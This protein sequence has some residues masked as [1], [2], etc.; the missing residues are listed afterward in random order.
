[1]MTTRRDER[2]DGSKCSEDEERLRV[3]MRSLEAGRNVAGP[4]ECRYTY[5]H[6]SK[7]SWVLYQTLDKGSVMAPRRWV[8][9][10]TKGYHLEL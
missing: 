9:R 2:R 7:M 10:I 6:I 1:M 4:D 3:R 8:D 5:T